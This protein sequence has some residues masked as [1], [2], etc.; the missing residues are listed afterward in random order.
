MTER[1]SIKILSHKTLDRFYPIE[2]DR[3]KTIIENISRSVGFRVLFFSPRFIPDNSAGDT[4]SCTFFSFTSIGRQTYRCTDVFFPRGFFLVPTFFICSSSVSRLFANV[5]KT[6]HEPHSPCHVMS[7]S[8]LFPD[9]Y[10]L[11]TPDPPDVQTVIPIE[12]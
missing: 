9:T 10:L 8:Q 2:C 1:N 11:Y 5:R 7:L 6:F 4:R 3:C 12:H